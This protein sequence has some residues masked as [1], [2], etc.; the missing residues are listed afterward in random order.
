MNDKKPTK[1]QASML[2]YIASHI[3]R[4]GYQPS[5]REIGDRFKIRSPNGVVSHL[6]S[7]ERKGVIDLNIR[8]ARAIK[9]DWRHWAKLHKGV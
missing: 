7:L 8:T 5:I 4:H 1:K 9:F 6:K 3:S 2:E